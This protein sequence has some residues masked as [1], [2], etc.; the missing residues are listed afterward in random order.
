MP[1]NHDNLIL[2]LDQIQDPGNLGTIIRLASWFGIEY[3]VCS[4]DTVDCYNPKV[5]QATM[6]A[7]A[8]VKVLY[9][10]LSLFLNESILKGR[11]IYGTF[12]DGD[13]IYGSELKENGI[14][15]LGNEGNGISKE[16]EKIV[17]N[18]LFIPSYQSSARNVESLNVSIAAAIVCSEFRRKKI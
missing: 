5:V 2:V 13:N 16:I 4:P 1:L 7:I 6:G 18:R 12:L 15:I 11:T 14:I 17:T 3:I 8:H 9:T 10:D